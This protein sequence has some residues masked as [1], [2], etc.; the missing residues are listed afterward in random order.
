MDFA[1]PLRRAEQEAAAQRTGNVTAPP[2][3]LPEAPPD[4]VLIEI[5]YR[6][7]SFP[8]SPDRRQALGSCPRV[9]RRRNAREGKGRKS[10]RVL[11]IVATVRYCRSEPS[12][13]PYRA[14]SSRIPDWKS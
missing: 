14:G 11:R 10:I 6:R 8:S 3:Q 4:N 7:G 2:R 13:V 1:G 12:G 5:F 9:T